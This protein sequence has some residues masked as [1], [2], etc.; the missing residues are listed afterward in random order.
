MSQSESAEVPC[1]RCHGTGRVTRPF[2]DEYGEPSDFGWVAEPCPDCGGT[3]K[4][5][6]REAE[7]PERPRPLPTHRPGGMPVK[8]RQ[9]VRHILAVHRDLLGDRGRLPGLRREVAGHARRHRRPRVR[10]PRRRAAGAG[11]RQREAGAHRGRGTR[12]EG[13]ADVAC[14]FPFPSLSKEFSYGQSSPQHDL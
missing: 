1:D 14:P 3:G 5:A 4:H 2:T 7:Q 12:S 10:R 13:Q 6:R 11:G 8:D 9:F